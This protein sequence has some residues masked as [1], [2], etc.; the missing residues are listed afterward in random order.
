MKFS[1]IMMLSKVAWFKVI[2]GFPVR[3][4]DG[5]ALGHFVCFN[6]SE[7]KEISLEKIELI[8]KLSISLAFKLTLKLNRK[9]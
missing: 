3:N 5:Y 7:V 4:K 6:F 1:K 2:C 9:N 8:E